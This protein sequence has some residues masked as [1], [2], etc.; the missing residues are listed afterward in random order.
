MKTF[1]GAIALATAG[2]A[3]HSTPSHPTEVSTEQLAAQSRANRQGRGSVLEGE[4]AESV[5]PLD[6][7]RSRGGD[8][9][10]GCG[11]AQGCGPR[12]SCGHQ[13]A[14]VFADREK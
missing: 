5:L 14:G 10:R 2:C 9:Q 11:S 3:A 8:C 7:D 13:H 4:E 6:T 1:L 12:L